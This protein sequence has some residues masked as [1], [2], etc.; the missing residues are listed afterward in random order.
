MGKKRPSSM[1]I[2]YLVVKSRVQEHWAAIT[3]SLDQYYF[4]LNYRNVLFIMTKYTKATKLRTYEA[5]RKGVIAAWLRPLRVTSITTFLNE[6]ARRLKTK[7]QI[8]F[9]PK[10]SVNFVIQYKVGLR[11]K[12]S[13]LVQCFCTWVYYLAQNLATYC[14]LMA[15]HLFT[16]SVS[17]LMRY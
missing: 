2:K 15:Y 14:L 10:W 3:T 4:A 11:D 7:F 8:Y 13:G 5:V 9:P 6:A 17:V 12:I 16:I 1:A